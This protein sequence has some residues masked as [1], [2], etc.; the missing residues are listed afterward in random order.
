[1]I[2]RIKVVL[3]TFCYVTTCVVCGT[4]IFM[5]VFYEAPQNGPEI[6]WQILLVSFLCSIGTLIY[7]DR[8]MSGRE[9]KIRIFIHYILVNIIVLGCGNGYRW[10]RV[11]DV[12][13]VI[14]ML[15]VIAAIFA[16]V[17][18]VMWHQEKKE[19]EQLNKKLQEYQ[20]N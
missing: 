6:L 9:M 17:S 16:I 10:F 2:E 8:E 14:G 13:M 18:G 3:T 5:D 20:G 7:P 11:G 12:G 15:V 19:A 4:A 1:M